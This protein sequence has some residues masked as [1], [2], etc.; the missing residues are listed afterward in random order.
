MIEISNFTHLAFTG[1]DIPS[2]TG[3]SKLLPHHAL[4]LVNACS[5]IILGGSA[6]RISLPFTAE[7]DERGFHLRSHFPAFRDDIA[8]YIR[9]SDKAEI[10]FDAGEY[11]IDPTWVLLDRPHA[12][13]EVKAVFSV[14]GAARFVDATREEAIDHLD[15]VR[16][17]RQIKYRPDSEF[18]VRNLPDDHLDKNLSQ[19]LHFEIDVERI[20][21]SQVMALTHLNTEHRSYIL[22][23]LDRVGDPKAQEAAQI[24]RFFA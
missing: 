4:S 6:C 7:R 10:L 15:R 21:V 18:T 16:A 20:E 12:P 8:S 23:Q 22:T 11:Y 5:G 2:V 3:K 13:T 24:M 14:I 9:N 1:L 17:F 19:I